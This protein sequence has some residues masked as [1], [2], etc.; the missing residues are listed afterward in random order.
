MIFDLRTTVLHL[1]LIKQI[2][3]VA[4]QYL[5]QQI[6]NDRLQG[7]YQFSIDDFRQLGFSENTAILLVQGLATTDA[8]NEE[9][10]L[11]EKNSSIRLITILDND[12]PAMLKHIHAPPPLLYIR[13]KPLTE[14]GK[15]I[16]IVGSRQANS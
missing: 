4:I 1:S 5:L 10:V 8:L 11:L 7:I 9:I 12:Y 3:P 15:S 16:A 6:K 2:G 14:Y 13:G